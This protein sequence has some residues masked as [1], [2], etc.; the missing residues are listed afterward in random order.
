[1]VGWSALQVECDTADEVEAWRA[2]LW[3]ARAA[4]EL[5]A[6][7]IVPGART[8]LLDGVPDPASVAASLRALPPPATRRRRR[9][10]SAAP[11]SRPSGPAQVMSMTYY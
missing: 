6:V 4:G 3:R 9:S 10:R 5:S 7:E 11:T 1:V 8:V 2:A